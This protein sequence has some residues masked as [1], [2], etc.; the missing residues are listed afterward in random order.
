[1]ALPG[2]AAKRAAHEQAHFRR[3]RFRGQYRR[4]HPR[5]ALVRSQG[6]GVDHVRLQQFLLVL[7]RAVCART[8]AVK[9]AR[10]DSRRSQGPHRG[11][12]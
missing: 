3:G 11:G 10:G 12:L 8:G 5:R 9:T 4:G 2:A 1:M 6:V 7:H